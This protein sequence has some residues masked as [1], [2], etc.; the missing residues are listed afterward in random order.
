MPRRS[1]LILNCL[2]AIAL[3]LFPVRTSS[4][5]SALSGAPIGIVRTAGRITIDGDLSDEGWQKA[6]RVDQWYETNP[7]DN[8]EPRVRNV[9]YLTFDD[10]YFYA[11]FEFED[12]NPAAIRAPYADRDNIGDGFN[13]YGGIIVDAGNTGH[14]AT[15]FVVTPH[16]IQ[17]DA[18]TDDASGEDSSPDFFWESATKITER[19]WTLEIRVP[20]TSLRYRNADP[21]TWG[22]LLYRNY[23]RDRHYQFFSA[24]LPRG[25]NCFICRSNT[26]T[27]LSGLPSGGHIVAAPYVSTTDTAHPRGD[28]GTP[29]ERDPFESHAGLDVKWTPNADN[30]IDLTVRPDFSQV[31]SDTAQISANE[32]FAL[33][34]PEKRPFFLEGVNLFSTP[35][36]AIYTRRI[37]SPNWGGRVTGKDAGIAYTAL[38]AEDDGGGSVIIPGPNGSSLAP[39][40]VKSTVL[41]ARLKKSIKQSFVS[42]AITDRQARE[43]DSHNLVIGPD[44]QWRPGSTEVVTGQ[45]L[46]S[47]TRTPIRPEAAS[48][49]NGQRFSSY[50]G[51]LQWSHNTTRYDAF[52]MYQNVGPGFRA[53]VGFVPQVGFRETF[54]STGWT[55]RPTG[56]VSRLRTF[57]S[58]DHQEDMSGALISRS[59]QPG[60]GMDTK[61]NGFLQFRY[62]DDRISAAGLPLRR[63]Q[64]G[65]VAQI[66]PSPMVSFIGI[67]GYAGEDIDFANG[68]LGRGATINLNATL[69]PTN[70]LELALVQNQRWLNVPDPRAIDA[71]RRRLFVARVS[72]MKSTY[73]FTARSFARVIAQYV[74]TDRDPLLYTSAVQPNSGSLSGS[75][76]FAYKLNWQSVMFVGYGDDREL[77]DLNRFEKADRQFFIKI[78]Y[79]FQR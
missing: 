59:V 6:T 60:F 4:A 53:D 66:S 74:T 67:N 79:A 17:Y 2:L 9:G 7:G 47:D 15:F 77:S 23:P 1:V 10:R 18:I 31:E 64:F 29:L 69:H 50:A 42:L 26:L 72:R 20:F 76:L 57:V 62:L 14:T 54:G 45:L 71:A 24:Q 5:Q 51:N 33:F 12:P 25:G 65:Y 56:I 63:R 27:G 43:G 37:T 40:D 11:A 19:G 48:E 21:Q 35:I 16:N 38:V 70:H 52:A 22:I 73:T 3:S 28:L 58:A 44:F 61:L 49:W 34:F 55:F 75:A 8:T 30:V 32:R 39:Q 13:D 68:R 46:V 78:S 36:Q 41:V